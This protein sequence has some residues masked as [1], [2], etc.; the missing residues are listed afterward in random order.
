MLPPDAC[1]DMDVPFELRGGRI[2]IT[3]RVGGRDLTAL[4]DTG[5]DGTA[6]DAGI[7]DGL[8]LPLKEAPKGTTVAGE[9]QLQ[10]TGPL[11]IDLGGRTLPADEVMV[12]PLAAQLPGVQAILGFDVLRHVPMTVDYAERRIRVGTLP[13]GDSLSFVLDEDMRP[14]TH[15][16]ALGGRFEAHLDTGSAQGVSLPLAWVQ[17]NAPEVLREETT[18]KILGAAV[19]SRRFVLGRFRIGKADLVDVPAEAVSAEGGSF[20]DAAQPWANVGNQVLTQFRIGLDGV[21]RITVL[22]R[23][24]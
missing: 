16:E 3:V 4:F 1:R 8:G 20:A 22:E 11:G 2:W 7:A 18:R 5:S 24:L 23:A 14:S 12:L 13:E 17:A 9:I 10:K 21:R 15:V 19:S 6:L